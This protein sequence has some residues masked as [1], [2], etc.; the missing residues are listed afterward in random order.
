[1]YQTK[2]GM[3]TCEGGFGPQKPVKTGLIRP[4]SRY[5]LAAGLTSVT[6][7]IFRP[8]RGGPLP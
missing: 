6:C 5:F 1:M 2:P 8:G 3:S 7:P 4:T